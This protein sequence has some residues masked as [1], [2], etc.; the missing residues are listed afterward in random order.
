MMSS[1]PSRAP[2]AIPASAPKFSAALQPFPYDSIPPGASGRRSVADGLA[3]FSDPATEGAAEAAARETQAR[4]QGRQEGL[5]EARKIFD[6][7]VERE[8]LNLAATLAQ[9]TRDRATYFQKVEGEVVQLALSIAR[10]ILHREAQLDPLLLAGIV[11]VALEQIDAATGVVLRIHPENAAEWRRYLATRLD[12][13][14]RPEIVEDPAQPPDR[15]TLETSMGRALI[16]LEVQLKEIE[17]GLMDLLAARPGVAS[18]AAANKGTA[19]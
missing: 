2:A 15:C 19:S 12:P 9:F 3:G 8:R 6:E 17:Q 18:P 13:A 16:G 11:R 5:N 1:S 10:K 7:Q 14:D 4:A